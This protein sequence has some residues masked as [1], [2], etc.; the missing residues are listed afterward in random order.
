ME[1]YVVEANRHAH[2]TAIL[3]K[4]DGRRLYEV[5]WDFFT[6]SGRE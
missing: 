5:V 2:P 6:H 4:E 3:D 1:L